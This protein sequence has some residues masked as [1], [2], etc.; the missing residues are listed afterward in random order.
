MSACRQQAQLDVP[1]ESVWLLVSNPDR[2][3]E[4]WPRIVEAQCPEALR[5]G[6][7]FPA[8]TQTP[9]GRLNTRLMVDGFD[10]CRELNIR[11]LNTGTYT[12]WSM[13]E[14]RGGTFIDAEFGMD[15]QNMPNRVFDAVAGKRYFRRWLEQSLEGLTA[16]AARVPVRP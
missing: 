16:A 13:T 1:L 2:Y 14:S 5:A 11:C 8:V 10:E 3:S 15:P 9:L 4:W 12:H 7:T 6:C